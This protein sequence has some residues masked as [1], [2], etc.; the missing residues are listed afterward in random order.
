MDFAQLL[1]DT[2]TLRKADGTVRKNIPAS[3]QQGAIII[4][5]KQVSFDPDDKL[6]RVLPNGQT[7]E[8]VIIDAHYTSD[9]DGAGDMAH[10]SIKYR[11]G[12]QQPTP[13]SSSIIYNV[14]GPNSRVNVQSADHSTNVVRAETPRVI[15]ELRRVVTVEIA[16]TNERTR[17][18]SKI[19]A[20]ES[21]YGHPSFLSKYQDFMTAAANH[22]TVLAPFFPVLSGLLSSIS[23]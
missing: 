23:G 17:L 21:S 19:T 15:E 12:G 9:P 8:L 4:F 18:L 2:V 6:S 1:A 7:E 14:T 22:V 13:P 16:D 10:W 20:L 11:R 5:D 3:V